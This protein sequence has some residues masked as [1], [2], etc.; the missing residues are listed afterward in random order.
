MCGSELV[1]LATGRDKKF[2]GAKCRVAYNRELTRWAKRCNDAAL[3]RQPE[4]ERD[5]GAPIQLASYVIQSDGSVEKRA[6]PDWHR[7]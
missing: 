3:A 1:H 5:F 6:R 4:P 7:S 2:C